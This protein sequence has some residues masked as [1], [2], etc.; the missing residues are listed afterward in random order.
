[1][2]TLPADPTMVSGRASGRPGGSA[3]GRRRGSAARPTE[4]RSRHKRQAPRV[5]HSAGVVARGDLIWADLGPPAG[6]SP[7]CALTRDAAIEVLAALTCAPITRTIRRRL[8]DAEGPAGLDHIAAKDDLG[9]S[10]DGP[11]KV[12]VQGVQ[13]GPLGSITAGGPDGDSDADAA[14]DHRSGAI[15]SAPDPGLSPLLLVKYGQKVVDGGL[16][17][18]RPVHHL[19]ARGTARRAAREWLARPRAHPRYSGRPRP[20]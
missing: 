18:C 12:S 16:A 13:P 9:P 7:V 20:P 6:R 3:P 17:G 11:E 5:A 10:S 15:G 4:S 19:I 1:M 8:A 14:E 2:P